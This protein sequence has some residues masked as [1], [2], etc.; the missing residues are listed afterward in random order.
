[1]VTSGVEE[2]NKRFSGLP[3]VVVFKLGIRLLDIHFI[4]YNL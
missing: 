4:I 1:M 2:E 3:D